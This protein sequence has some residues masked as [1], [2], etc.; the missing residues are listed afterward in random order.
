MGIALIVLGL[1]LWF[2]LAFNGSVGETFVDYSFF[3]SAALM[4][5]AGIL[6]LVKGKSNLARMV[7]ALAFLSY[8]PMIWQRFN[9]SSSTDSVGLYFDIGIIVFLLIFIAINP[10]RKLKQETP[11]GG[12]P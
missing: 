6:R 5:V 7:G 4:I 10:S 9:F 1:F 2:A 12:A 8:M 3:T 11:R